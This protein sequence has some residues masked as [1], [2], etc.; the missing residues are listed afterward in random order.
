MLFR[1]KSLSYGSPKK[2]NIGALAIERQ[3]Q[4]IIWHWTGS[5]SRRSTKFWSDVG[6]ISDLP[7]TCGLK[8]IQ[9][10]GATVKHGG[11]SVMVGVLKLEVWIWFCQKPSLSADKRFW[12]KMEVLVRIWTRV[13]LND[14]QRHSPACSFAWVKNARTD[15][16]VYEV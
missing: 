14:C 10:I 1:K 8:N 9:N 2:I 5:W 16:S 4:I 12:S 15:W 3:L 7:V 11:G 6:V 13:Q